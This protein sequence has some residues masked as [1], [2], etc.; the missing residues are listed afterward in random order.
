MAKIFWLSVFLRP[1]EGYGQCLPL[2][3]TWCPVAVSGNISYFRL[4]RAGGASTLAAAATSVFY[5]IL[6]GESGFLDGVKTSVWRTLQLGARKLAPNL[7]EC[8]EE[9]EPGGFLVPYDGGEEFQGFAVIVA[10]DMVTAI[11]L[12]TDYDPWQYDFEEGDVLPIIE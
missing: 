10:K 6:R 2:H 1:V 9:K 4:M 3:R 7:P 11:G 5:P 8:P 12:A